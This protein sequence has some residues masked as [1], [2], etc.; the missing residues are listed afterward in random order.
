MQ[1]LTEEIYSN[2]FSRNSGLLTP[3][4]QL[5]LK[6]SRIA[7]AGLGGVGGIQAVTLARAGVGKF[8]I[9]D[10]ETFQFSDHNRQY[11]AMKS[12]YGKNKAEVMKGI[13]QDINPTCEV[14]VFER[15][16]NSKNITEF[17]QG[18]DVVIDAIE[19]FSLEE[20][21]FLYNEA[22]KN[23]RYV[24]T[25]PIIGFGASLLT[26]DPKGLSFDEYFELNKKHKLSLQRLCPKYPDYLPEDLYNK[27]IEGKRSIPS[28]SVSAVLSGALLS[29]EVVLYL[30]KKCVPTTVP[31]V[32]QVDLYKK[33][34]EVTKGDWTE[35]WTSFSQEAYENISK[36]SEYR[37]MIKKIES[38]TGKGKKILDAGCGTGYLTKQLARKNKVVAI[39]FSEG[40]LEKVKKRVSN[41]KKVSVKKGNV[42]N[43]EFDAELFDV[44]TSVNVLFN[45]ST[46][47]LAL[48]EANRVLKKG[49]KLIIS[50]LLKSKGISED[51]GKK[52]MLD[53]KKSKISKRKMEKIWEFQKILLMNGGF[54]FQPSFEEICKMIVENGF[55]I[56]K[57]EVAYF[58]S[59]FL[60]SAVKVK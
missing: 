51:V 32:V 58:S 39:D 12:T 15:G 27:S 60:I 6:S 5:V 9:A 40:M 49:G 52:F 41:L 11:G 30:T 17:I 42:T 2:L 44:V 3:E 26:F 47:E 31:D 38:W 55:R 16:I 54:C 48:K 28:F 43:L 25:C 13:I 1:A 57:K 33:S 36:L 37:K 22:R 24:F 21:R 59:N 10:P 35:F 53:C 23:G 18:C 4:E 34:I 20:K 46:P 56:E 7:I 14:K 45:L 50:S 8:N 29:N 19:Y